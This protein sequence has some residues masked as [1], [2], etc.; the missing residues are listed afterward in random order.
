LGTGF[1]KDSDEETDTREKKLF[2]RTSCVPRLFRSFLKFFNGERRWQE[3]Q[4]SLIPEVRNRYHRLNIEFFGDE[5]QLDDLQVM[6]NLKKQAA[7]QALSSGDV[8]KC[9]DNL[10]A[11][12][13][14]IELLAVPIFNRGWFTCTGR[15]LCRLARSD[16]A[17]RTLARRLRDTKA[18]FYLDFDQKLPC[19]TEQSYRAID[20]GAAFS[21]GI[22]FKVSSL[23]ALVDIKIDGL[24]K[25]ARSISN[26]PYMIETLIKDQGLHYTFGSRSGKKRIQPERVLR[27]PKRVRHL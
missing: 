15:I 26:C 14:Y 19:V 18:H 3:L 25:R 12:L 16:H 2:L 4:N 24:T 23:Q 9:A 8:Q 27:D 20:C 11:A 5:P 21:Q 6:P 7:L 1:R 17:L 10:L 22:V 13:F